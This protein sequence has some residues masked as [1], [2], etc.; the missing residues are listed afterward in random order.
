[1]IPFVEYSGKRKMTERENKSIACRRFQE[2]GEFDH[3]REAWKTY[4]GISCFLV[5]VKFMRLFVKIHKL[6]IRKSKFKNKKK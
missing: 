3:E 1:M 4:G 6:Y 5:E 2:E